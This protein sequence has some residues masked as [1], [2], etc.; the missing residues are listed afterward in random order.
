VAFTLDR[1]R[2]PVHLSDGADRLHP[3]VLTAVGL[4]LPRLAEQPGIEEDSERFLSKLGSLA[5]LALSAAVQKRAYLRLRNRTR[6]ADLPAVTGGFLLDRAR[7]VVTPIGLDAV[8]ARFV[9]RGLCSG[10]QALH[11]GRRIVQRLREVL[12]QDGRAAQMETCVDGPWSFSLDRPAAA[13]SEPSHAAGLTPWDASAS[14]G[15]QIRAAGVLHAAAE[16]GTLALFVP[17]DPA[18]TGEEATGWLHFA[19][20]QSE[21]VRI[22]FVRATPSSSQLA[23]PGNPTPPASSGR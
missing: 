13:W 8:V 11:F 23:S 20:T 7:L 17:D 2:R 12:R 15:A 19:W 5:R 22:R 21:I 18:P 14:A 3:A 9:R 6:P 10:G 16:A 4:H 1:P